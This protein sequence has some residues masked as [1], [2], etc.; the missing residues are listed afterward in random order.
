MFDEQRQGSIEAGKL[1]DLV[2]L[3]ENTLTAAPNAMRDAASSMT[4]VGGKI[5]H[6][7]M[8]RRLLLQCAGSPPSGR[9]AVPGCSRMAP[10]VAAP[11]DQARI[12]CARRRRASG[13]ARCAG[14][15]QG[16]WPPFWRGSATTAP[17]PTPITATASLGCGEL[18]PRRPRNIPTQ[19]E[20][21]ETAARARGRSFGDLPR[22]DR[23]SILEAAIA[24]AKIERLPARPDGGHIATDL[25]AFYFNSID[26][27]DLCYRAAIGR[28]YLPRARGLERAAGAAHT[29]RPLMPT[30]EC[31]ICIIGGGISAALLAQKRHASCGPA[32][33]SSSSK[34]AIACSTRRSAL[35]DRQRALAYGEN[36][37]PGDAID[38]Q[39]AAGIISRTMAVGGSALHWGGVTNRFSEE[40]LR[41]KSMYGLAADWPIEWAELERF[42]CEAERRIGVS[43]EPGP[44]AED[45]RSEPYPMAADAAVVEPAAAESVGREERHSV[46]DD[47]AGQEHGAVRRPQRMQALQHLRDLSDRR[48]LFAGRDVPASAGV[49]GDRAA[50]S[51]AGPAARARGR[52][53]QDAA[54][55]RGA[56]RAPRSA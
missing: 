18:P 30:F 55:R 36:P 32:R 43:G 26:A 41:L 35:L 13:G 5:V 17:A 53:R 42:Y 15:G 39:A 2:V 48:A 6:R 7:T 23:R 9:L 44:L 1:A 31:D 40:D 10:Q 3:S 54:H 51:H 33:R 11:A 45:R 56:G 19:L 22:D 21:L 47:A 46:L 28:D 27:N 49:Q 8:K 12:R 38:D 34:P 24:A 52:R 29:R 25:M 37:W 50:R 20:A 16:R 4:M 14:A